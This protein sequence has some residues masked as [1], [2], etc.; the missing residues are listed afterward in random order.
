MSMLKTIGHSSRVKKNQLKLQAQVVKPP[1]F[2]KASTGTCNAALAR[3]KW[4]WLVRKGREEKLCGGNPHWTKPNQV[5]FWSRDFSIAEVNFTIVRLFELKRNSAF[6]LAWHCAVYAVNWE[7]KQI[8]ILYLPLQKLNSCMLLEISMVNWSSCNC[9]NLLRLVSS[10]IFSSFQ[11]TGPAS[12]LLILQIRHICKEKSAASFYAWPLLLEFTTY[13]VVLFHYLALDVW[14]P[15]P[16]SKQ[17]N[18]LAWFILLHIQVLET[19]VSRSWTPR[20]SYR[21]KRDI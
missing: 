2:L 1:V 15:L 16:A 9:L 5:G 20:S 14:Q 10:S 18:V 7:R 8:V 19:P 13:Q 17:S 21:W 12:A 4:L 6:G 3:W 11:R